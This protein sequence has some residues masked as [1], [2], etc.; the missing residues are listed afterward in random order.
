M[1]FEED[2]DEASAMSSGSR[3]DC[4]LRRRRRLRG[5][6]PRAVAVRKLCGVCEKD[7]AGA[8]RLAWERY[9]YQYYAAGRATTSADARLK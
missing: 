6:S 3:L 7:A 5:A 8:R 1:S 2:E 9:E 4:R